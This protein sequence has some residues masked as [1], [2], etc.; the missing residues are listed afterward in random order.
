MSLTIDEVR[1]I[2]LL[3]R[4]RLSPGEEALFAP[5]LGQILDFVAQLAAYSTAPPVSRETPALEAADQP[6]WSMPRHEL[7]ANA[8]AKLDA[9]LLVP[10]VKVRADE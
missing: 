6:G 2:A 3:A 1:R 5:Q 4:L 10:Q 7:L 9:F 8:P